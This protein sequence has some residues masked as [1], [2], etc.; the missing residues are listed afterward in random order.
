VALALLSL[1]VQEVGLQCERIQ[2]FH[3]QAQVRSGLT[4]KTSYHY[5]LMIK[6]K[7]LRALAWLVP[8]L[9]LLHPIKSQIQ[10]CDYQNDN[11]PY[12]GDEACDV[13]LGYCFADC[14]DCDNCRQ[15]DLDCS[16]CLVDGCVYCPKDGL[17][18]S[19]MIPQDYFAPSNAKVPA[20]SSQDYQSES[21]VADADNV[22][23]DPF[24]TEQSWVYD[25]IDVEPV[26]RRGITGEGVH[27]R[28]NDDGVNGNHPELSARFDKEGSCENYMPFDPTE[29]THGT[30]CAAIAAGE[31]NNNECS[32]G[33]APGAT[34][35]SCAFLNEQSTPE[36]SDGHSFLA[37]G[38]EYVDI[39]SNS[40]NQDAC[41]DERLIGQR[42]ARLLQN[43]C[44]FPN[45]NSLSPCRACFDSEFDLT[46]A[47][48]EQCINAIDK[49]CYF[50]YEG[51]EDV[52]QEYIDLF[53]KC[54]YNMLSTGERTTVERAIREGRAGKGMIYTF[55]AGNENSNGEDANMEGF[56]HSRYTISVAGV[57]RNGLHASYSTPGA[58]NLITAPGGDSESL[59]NN[60]VALATGGCYD[61]T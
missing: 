32:A 47:P 30:T 16:A 48:D 38:I 9:L 49:F 54:T 44:P 42:R 1:I 10:T 37:H 15:Y 60:V 6:V 2:N 51:Y 29:N 61:A 39:S 22:F 7:E 40:W 46:V 27:I 3:V 19:G 41:G 45:D 23:N 57:G 36:A 31:A 14:F 11:C 56:M 26:W 33:I 43:K 13:D 59:H 12:K 18:V 52:C 35:S 55:A 28:I 34:V 58:P 4:S 50:S 17:C 25:L 24:Y 5:H 21:C 53:V 20:C 8:L